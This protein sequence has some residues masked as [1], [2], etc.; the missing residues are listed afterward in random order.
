MG[1]RQVLVEMRV[2]Q[3]ASARRVRELADQLID[4]GFEWD[5]EY[6]VP[7]DDPTTKGEGEG[8]RYRRVLLRGQIEEEREPELEAHSNILHVWSDAP[9]A[10]LSSAAEEET[11][12]LKSA[13]TF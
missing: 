2:P 5:P 4:Y 3:R 11:P 12:P 7:L 13:F 8:G 6:L 1:R 10:P 9:I